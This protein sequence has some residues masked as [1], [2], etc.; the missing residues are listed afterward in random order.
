ME[1]KLMLTIA[2]LAMLAIASQ[3]LVWVFVERVPATDFSGPLRS[4]Y[5]L[6][7]F[8]LDALDADGQH[9]FSIVAPRLVRKD[10]DGSIFV[11]TPDYVI[12]DNSGNVWKGTSDSAWVNKGGTVMKLEG[13]VDMHRLPTAKTAPAQLLTSDLTVTTSPKAKGT[14]QSQGK[15]KIMQTTALTTITTP[16]H[17]VHGVGMHA[18]MGLKVVELFSDVHW[19]ALPTTHAHTQN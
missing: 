6:D 12:I 1:R 17:V 9:A 16:G 15:E 3:I 19:I 13:K 14:T 10:E 7:D 8:T 18:D 11:T 5:T 2:A 4:G